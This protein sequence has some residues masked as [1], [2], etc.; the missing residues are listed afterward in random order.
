MKFQ[1]GQTPLELA[2]SLDYKETIRIIVQK[3]IEDSEKGRQENLQPKKKKIK[4]EDCIICCCQ[5]DAIYVMYPCGHA[6]TCETCCLKILNSSDTQ[7]VC[8]VC[9]E[10]AENYVKVFY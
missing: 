4:L 6:K 3:M 9:R 10:K 5:R 7:P 1:T 8:P 2:K